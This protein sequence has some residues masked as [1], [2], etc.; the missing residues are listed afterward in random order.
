MIYKDIKV[1]DLQA[2]ARTARLVTNGVNFFFAA[3]KSFDANNAISVNFVLT[4]KNSIVNFVLAV[5]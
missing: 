3:V 4:A 5:S 2:Y 1:S